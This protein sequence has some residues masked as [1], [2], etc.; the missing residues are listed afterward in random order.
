MQDLL[1]NLTHFSGVKSLDLSEN[2]TVSDEHLG[3]LPGFP[4]LVSLDLRAT[5]VTGQGLDLHPGA[6]RLRRLWITGRATRTIAGYV[7]PLELEVLELGGPGSSEA[8]RTTKTDRL[9]S[10]ILHDSEG[11]DD[12]SL[13]RLSETTELEYLDLRGTP[14][15]DDALVGLR[16]LKNLRYLSLGEDGRVFANSPG[17]YPASGPVLTDSS[18]PHLAGLVQLKSLNLSFNGI[19]GHNL[20]YLQDLALLTSLELGCNAIDD[21]GLANLP[22]LPSLMH[23]ELFGNPI[24]SEGAA[25]LAKQE[26]LRLLGARATFASK[27]ELSEILPRCFNDAQPREEHRSNL[28][29]L[30]RRRADAN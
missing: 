3:F 16:G 1:P 18:F 12:S 6:H 5:R 8:L 11:L 27:E 9:R 15:P 17:R 28:R 10:L 7:A 13:D 20:S 24:T 4:A 22:V 26:R 29:T 25:V 23:L 2:P 14:S 30:L 19:E 21:S